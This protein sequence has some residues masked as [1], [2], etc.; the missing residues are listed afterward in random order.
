MDSFNEDTRSIFS[1]TNGENSFYNESRFSIRT[2]NL[3]QRIIAK[4]SSSFTDALLIE[5]K[6]NEI[7]Y[8]R[9]TL[10]SN[11][12][13]HLRKE[14]ALQ[15]HQKEAVMK[16]SQFI[17]DHLDT[18][19]NVSKLAENF[20]INAVTLQNGFKKFFNK[21]VNEFVILA[22]LEKAR[23]LF[24]ATDMTIGEIGFD[25]GITSKSYI[26]KVFKARYGLTPRDYR[27]SRIK[28]LGFY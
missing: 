7:L 16:A 25:I 4:K 18:Y 12:K 11:K 17:V 21:T 2:L 19:E 14:Y 13:V 5:S 20:G 22:R 27:N 23:R 1:D 15:S 28:T 6:L 8:N 26:S 3:I 10:F 24:E 9:L